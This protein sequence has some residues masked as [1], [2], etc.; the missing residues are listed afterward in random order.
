[1]QRNEYW[2]GDF[3]ISVWL[4]ES[5]VWM[6]KLYTI[7]NLLHQVFFL[8]IASDH[9]VI[10][11]VRDTRIPIRAKHS[12]KIF[13][14]RAFL[15]DSYLFSWDGIALFRWHWKYFHT[16]FLRTVNKHEF[17]SFIDERRTFEVYQRSDEIMRYAGQ[18]NLLGRRDSGPADLTH[19]ELPYIGLKH[20]RRLTSRA[21]M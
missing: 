13:E 7:L 19:I 5:T 16:S 1:M 4:T 11:A 9:C 6:F 21:S 18:E 14:M 20:C 2:V 12:V 10:A 15:R 8:I 3:H 17:A